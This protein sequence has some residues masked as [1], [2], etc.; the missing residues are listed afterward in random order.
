[1]SHPNRFR[2]CRSLSPT[3]SSLFDMTS[4]AGEIGQPISTAG[5]AHH[6]RARRSAASARAAASAT[7][8]A[9]A[10]AAAAAAAGGSSRAG[11]ASDSDVAG[12]RG[13]AS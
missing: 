2:S 3:S 4:T 11:G 8:G 9:A 10:A 5:A 13:D 12:A 1:V 6:G 7:V